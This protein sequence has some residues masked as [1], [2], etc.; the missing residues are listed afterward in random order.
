MSKSELTTVEPN[1]SVSIRWHEA[2][3]T[4]D[5]ESAYRDCLAPDFVADLFGQGK[6]GRDAFIRRDRLFA[7]AFAENHVVVLDI[8]GEG[9]VVM[10]RMHWTAIHSGRLDDLEPTGR[11][12]DIYGFGL[13]RFRDGHVMEHIPLFDQWKLMQQL[14]S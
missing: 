4:R 10:T 1:K 8:V 3:G 2:W 14:R 7:S 13:D 11:R 12:V 9:D 5:I 6:V